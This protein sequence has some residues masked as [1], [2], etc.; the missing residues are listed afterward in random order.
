MILVLAP[1]EGVIDPV[2]RH[3][4]TRVGGYSLCVT[5]FVR[6]TGQ[7][8]PKK[9]FLQYC[10]ELKNGGRTATGVPVFVQLL[11]SDPL[12]LCENALFAK[13]LG[14]LGI[15]LNFGCPAKTVNQHDGGASLLKNPERIFKIIHSIRTHLPADYPLSAKVRLGFA[16]KTLHREIAQAAA[17]GGASWLSVHARTKLEAYQPPAHWHY[18]AA[19]KEA[20][21]IPVLANGDIWSPQDWQ[22]CKQE[23]QCEDFLLGRGAFARP[24]LANEILARQASSGPSRLGKLYPLLQNRG[25]PANLLSSWSEVYDLYRYF[26]TLNYRVYGEAHSL[27]RGKQWLKFLSRNFNEAGESFEICRRIQSFAE[28]LNFHHCPAPNAKPEGFAALFSSET[29]NYMNFA[30][31][32]F[33][34]RPHTTITDTPASHA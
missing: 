30:D 33:I 21:N 5:E 18:I 4:Y 12:S 34:I 13:D 3:L 16:D 1:M 10:P 9:V 32:S 28:F 11:G 25:Q 29:K 26:L 23:S 14:A 17:E 2:L 31:K 19:M 27:R 6:V 7:L 22:Q 20:V 24:G 8:L 15:D